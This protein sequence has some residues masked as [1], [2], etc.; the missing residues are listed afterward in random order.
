MSMVER[1]ESD[2]WGEPVTVTD[3]GITYTG[4]PDRVSKRVAWNACGVS[5]PDPYES[6]GGMIPDPPQHVEQYVDVLIE[7]VQVPE[8][9]PVVTRPLFTV[10][11]SVA[12]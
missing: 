8:T 1:E 3:W 2:V 7:S 4:D 9:V 12:R 11:D 6:R 5:S 10:P